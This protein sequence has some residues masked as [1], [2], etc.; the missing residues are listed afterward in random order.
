M[1]TA[2]PPYPCNTPRT[3]SQF[4]SSLPLCPLS[5]LS[6]LCILSPRLAVKLL[7]PSPV[8]LFASP[9]APPHRSPAN[10]PASRVRPPTAR[11]LEAYI[12]LSC[13]A[14]RNPHRLDR[15][16]LK[17][18]L[19]IWVLTSTPT[20]RRLAASPPSTAPRHSTNHNA[21]RPTRLLTVVASPCV[22]P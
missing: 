21:L 6:N 14:P 18:S 15:T 8:R 4:G 11:H 13:T 20:A 10:I 17:A 5:S 9:P 19:H 2:E 12:G 3:T 1:T 22:T 16:S 7:P